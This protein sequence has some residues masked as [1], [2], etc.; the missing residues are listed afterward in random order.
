MSKS[1]SQHY[2]LQRI[3]AFF[4]IPLTIWFVICMI[5]II[6]DGISESTYG[7]ISSPL[8]MVLSICFVGLVI[9]HGLLG[10]EN[11]L[12]DYVHCNI[13]KSWMLNGLYALSAISFLSYF[14]AAMYFHIIFRMM[15]K[16][17]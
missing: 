16:V 11:I 8:H 4:L 5:I 17:G 14:I 13:L 10:I 2:S 12:Q 1:A 15:F 7:I 3:T 6:R 9:Y